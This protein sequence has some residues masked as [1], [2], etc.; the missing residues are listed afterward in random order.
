MLVKVI[1]LKEKIFEG[2]ALSVKLPSLKGEIEVLDNHAHIFTLLQKGEIK[3]QTKS[4]LKVFQ[5]NSGI[6]EFFENKL[7]VLLKGQN[8]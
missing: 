3:I 2:E 5:I 6:A 7:L 1:S 8:A 4:Q